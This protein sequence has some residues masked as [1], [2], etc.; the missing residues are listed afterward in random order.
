MRLQFFKIIVLIFV[1]SIVVLSTFFLISLDKTTLNNKNEN[2]IPIKSTTSSAVISTKSSDLF[3]PIKKVVVLEREIIKEVIKEVCNNNKIESIPNSS[4]HLKL[5]NNNNNLNNNSNNLDNNNT[6]NNNNNNNNKNININNNNKNNL[7]EDQLYGF[8]DKQSMINYF[9]SYQNYYFLEEN[10][11]QHMN[12]SNYDLSKYQF[13]ELLKIESDFKPTIDET[14]KNI[15]KLRE[16]YY[17][18]Q[19]KQSSSFEKDKIINNNNNN[20]LGEEEKNKNDFFKN[21]NIDYEITEILKRGINGIQD[22]KRL[23]ELDEMKSNGHHPNYYLQS[24]TPSQIIE[25]NNTDG[26]YKQSLKIIK[27]RLWSDFYSNYWR[28]KNFIKYSIDN[29]LIP[30]EPPKL[31][32]PLNTSTPLL[33]TPYIFIHLPKVGGTSMQ[34]HF[35]KQFNQDSIQQWTFPNSKEIINVQNA[36]SVI[37]G[38]F[39]YGLHYVLKEDSQKTYNYLTMLRDPVDRVI[40]HY[41]YHKSTTFDQEHMVAR[42]NTFDQWLEVSPRG[43]NEMTRQLSGIFETEEFTP[44]NETFNM[45][46]YHLRSMKFV[47]ITERFEETLALLKFYIGLDNSDVSNKKNVAQTKPSGVSPEII[48]KIKEKNWMDILL[49]EEALK[50]FERQINIVGRDNFENQ[51]NKILKK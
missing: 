38:H 39:G 4:E 6:N 2:I 35:K 10:N 1:S 23:E 5:T 3:T 22:I 42:N 51:L 8:K 26:Y 32:L 16:E 28:D 12:K 48:E 34:Y 19:I 13:P 7:N 49:Y 15:E 37:L 43:T 47:G 46:L 18:S 29:S 27:S 40:S 20:I 36:K 25:F 9:L 41:F 30:F 33:T 21:I 31:S 11:Y 24:P 50:M 17:I 45:A 44:T 14:K